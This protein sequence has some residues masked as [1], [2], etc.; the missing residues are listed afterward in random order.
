[1]D[2]RK[3]KTLPI[4][5]SDQSDSLPNQVVPLPD[6]YHPFKEL[7]KAELTS[8]LSTEQ[9]GLL[10]QNMPIGG[11]EEDYSAAKKEIDK[12][13]LKGIDDLAAYFREHPEYL[14]EIISSVKV[15]SVNQALLDMRRAESIEAFILDEGAIDEWWNDDW[16]N[17]Y[18]AELA[19]LSG[20]NCYF[21]AGIED[22][23]V[24]WSPYQ[25]R[26]T[27][28]VVAGHEDSWQR[29]VSIYE[30][31]TESKKIEKQ[32]S[33]SKSDLELQV[34]ERT[35]ELRE[36][37]TLLTQSAEMA[38][39]GYAIWDYAFEK[40]ITASEGYA[41]I[42]GYDRDQFLATFASVENHQQVLHP[43]D[44]ESYQ[45]YYEEFDPQHQSPDITFRIIRQ[46]GETRH[47]LQSRKHVF[48]AFGERTQSLL[49]IQDVTDRKLVEEELEN[50]YALYRQAEA[51]GSMGHWSWD[52]L[53]Y[54]M[55][56]CSEQFARIYDMTVAEAIDYFSNLDSEINT[57]HPDDRERYSHALGVSDAQGKG[58]D[59]E[60]RMIAPSGI[61]RHLY[62]RS[63]RIYDEN[64][65]L[66]RSFGTVQDITERKKIEQDLITQG[67]ITSHM[68]EGAMLVRASD[69]TIVY[70]NQAFEGM[71]GYDNGELLGRHISVLN[72]PTELTS[73]EAADQQISE[74]KS[75]GVWQGEVRNIK[76]D[77]STFWSSINMSRFY[78]SEFG[79]VWVSINSDTTKRRRAEK[80]LN[81]QARH[82][83]L[84]GLKNRQEFERRAKRL[85]LGAREGEEV[86]AMCFLDLDQFK[87]V[88]DTCGH[89]AGDELLR[90]LA[91]VLRIALRR[92]D[93]LARLGGD[94]FGVLMAHCTQ[95][96][97]HRAADALLKRI[98]DFQFSWEDQSFR[99]GVSIGLVSIDE[100]TVNM[101]ELMKQADAACYMAKD[102]GRNRIHVYRPED[103]EL[104]KRSG[105]MQWLAQINQALEDDRFTLYVQEIAPLGDSGGSCYELLLRMIDEDGKIILPSAFLPAAER[106]DLV[107]KLDAWV[108]SKACSLFIS[109]PDFVEQIQFVSVNISGQ[110]L[111]NNRFLESIV[112]YF[113]KHKINASKI[114]FEVTETAAISNL[115]AATTFIT[116]LKEFG[117]H[118][119]LDDFGSGLSSFGYLKNLPVEYLKIDGMYVKD[120]VDDPIDHAMVK[121][122]NEIGHVMGMKT[123]AEFVECDA[124]KSSL[125]EL[126]VD[127]VQGNGISK[128]EPLEE[129]IK[130]SGIAH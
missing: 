114:C 124:V 29:I 122:I 63:D 123:I 71:F 5:N 61:H 112:A 9:Y 57:V 27:S 69:E 8:K 44:H 49:S 24:D 79:E 4:V 117:C 42:Y 23:R 25:F 47:I 103:T 97:A 118:F 105:E 89:T 91:Q 59:I 90:Q 68:V 78:H 54:K 84:T 107:E 102:L 52:H 130:R 33:E 15:V 16:A 99:L 53:K 17:Y 32:I 125:V 22:T 34:K 81:Y 2:S 26:V 66:V 56:A 35:R 110:S 43:E 85:I 65:S 14:L 1:M 95:E 55:T 73:T 46:D 37:E 64:G 80:K 19:N 77:G 115:S 82:D 20:N 116:R 10:F 83:V 67:Q 12:L 13:N 120:M 98:E 76:K 45:A 39:L 48:D 75:Q 86:H 129:L 100:T 119:A 40:Y 96:K 106:Y 31:I 21:G 62:L 38:N 93:T 127:F 126:G 74:I 11:I 128:P 108:V 41:R 6:K 70:T 58:M 113:E 3:K 51:M 50:S 30:D 94:E 121:S 7:H 109:H 28:F 88:N 92:G 104:A 18:A 111:S 72:A 60:Y 36:R 101:L 87:I